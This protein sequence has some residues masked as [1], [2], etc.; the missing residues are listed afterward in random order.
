MWQYIG[1]RAQSGSKLS[2][3]GPSLQV[4]GQSSLLYS[5]NYGHTA[6]QC[7]V[8]VLV[9]WLAAAARV[10]LGSSSVVDGNITHNKTNV[11]SGQI[12]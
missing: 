3:T 7:T 6:V 2:H 5:A 4:F 1:L 10:A 9:P 8:T 12:T 11:T